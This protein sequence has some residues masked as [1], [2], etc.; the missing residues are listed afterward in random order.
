MNELKPCPF[1]GSTVYL[2]DVAT[3][4]SGIEL[5]DVYCANHQCYLSGGT[6]NIYETRQLAI[7][8]WN[9]RAESQDIAHLREQVKV[10]RE[11]LGSAER[12]IRNGLELGYIVPPETGD[13]ACETLAVICE[14][15]VH[16]TPKD[17]E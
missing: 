4:P 7:E 12:Y 8:A 16:T 6:N 5:W 13:P 17:G 9:S 2:L 1:C 11:A 15:L 3:Q 14:A 10:L